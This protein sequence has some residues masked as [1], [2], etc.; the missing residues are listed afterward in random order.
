M[1]E[2]TNILLSV[3]TALIRPLPCVRTAVSVFKLINFAMAFLFAQTAQMNRENGP[4]PSRSPLGPIVLTVHTRTQFIV[5]AL[6]MSVLPF[7]MVCLSVQTGGMSFYPHVRLMKKLAPQ[8]TVCI[9]VKTA[10]CV[11]LREICVIKDRIATLVEKMNQLIPA[12]LVYVLIHILSLAITALVFGEIRHVVH[13]L[14]LCVRMDAI[15][16]Q[17]F[18]MVSVTMISP[19]QKTRT[20]YLVKITVGAFSEHRFAI[21]YLTVLEPLMR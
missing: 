11:L 1:M 8:T 15:C 12:K 19:L 4:G 10:Q 21:P 17:T 9:R 2:V 14:S 3:T 13:I 7:A 20:V 6:L 5:Q 16:I 18:V